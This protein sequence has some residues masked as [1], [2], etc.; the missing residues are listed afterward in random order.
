MGRQRA[1]I[2][3]LIVCAGNTCRSPMAR[4][5]LRR[6]ASERGINMDVRTAGLAH[7]PNRGVAEHA[8][9]VMREL[10]IDISDDYS[11]PVTAAALQWA[12]III[13]LQRSLVDELLEDYPELA[14]KLRSLDRD[15]RDPYCGTVKDYREVRDELH[16]L[17]SRLVLT[18]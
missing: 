3:V 18:P 1:K 13:S 16:R 4:G 15:V 6:V 12:D 2:R 9:S 17:L 10:E 8:V 7:H 11:K 5:I 14:D